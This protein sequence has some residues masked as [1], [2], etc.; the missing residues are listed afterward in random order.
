MKLQGYRKLIAFALCLL[1]IVGM[2]ALGVAADTPYYA[3]SALLA[4]FTA[5]NWAEHRGAAAPAGT[6]T[7]ST[8]DAAAPV[9]QPY[10]SVPCA[11]VA[12]PGPFQKPWNQH[13][14][15]EEETT[16]YVPND[17]PPSKRRK[18]A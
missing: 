9:V 11:Q 13:A 15:F 8:P 10:I 17:A 6:A 18:R 5:G 14:T 7:G 4:A 1:A 16:A 12:E 3:V 2:A